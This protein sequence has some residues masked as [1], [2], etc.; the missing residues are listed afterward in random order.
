[1][2]VR[3]CLCCC[4]VCG[5]NWYAWRETLETVSLVDDYCSK[6]RQFVKVRV[7]PCEFNYRW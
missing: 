2:S 5:L 1:M 3:F 7:V 4:S 6:C